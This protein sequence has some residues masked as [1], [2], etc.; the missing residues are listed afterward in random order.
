MLQTGLKRIP[1]A[2]IESP[3]NRLE[4]DPVGS[5]KFQKNRAGNGMLDPQGKLLW[6]EAGS[7]LT[8][9]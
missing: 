1:R 8:G 3:W 5:G 9:T 7:V 4:Y 2:V 6:K